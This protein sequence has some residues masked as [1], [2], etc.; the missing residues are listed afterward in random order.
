[1]RGEFLSSFWLGG[2]GWAD[3]HRLWSRLILHYWATAMYKDAV[4]HRDGGYE[5]KPV[6]Y[7]ERA[8]ERTKEATSAGG[9]D[10]QGT[11]T[12]A[13]AQ[14]HF[15]RTEGGGEGVEPLLYVT[16]VG[17]SQVMVV[18]PGTREVVYKSTEQWH[19]FD[20]PRQLGTNSPDTPGGCAVVDEVWIRE[21][22]VVLAMS[23]GVIDNLWMHEIVE[24]VCGSV[25]RWKGGR[26]E[27]K[28]RPGEGEDEAGMRFVAEELKEAARK[29]AVDPFA[30]SPFMERAIEEGLPSEGGEWFWFLSLEWAAD[31][32]VYRQAGRYQRGGGAV[33]EERVDVCLGAY[34]GGMVCERRYGWVF[35]SL[36]VEH[37][38]RAGCTAH[39]YST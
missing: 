26:A 10:W 9:S 39:P 17:D 27:V 7:L 34:G 19:W 12:A 33:Q 8:Y 2:R 14:L 36:S 13:G 16:N 4:R 24:C 38:E 20:C 28:V 22:D 18:R 32:V 15:R 23:D 30:E 25:E 31:R 11:T 1:M 37:G 3:V 21:G 29:I 5:P 35:C 6:E